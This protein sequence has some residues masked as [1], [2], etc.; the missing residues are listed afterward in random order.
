[1]QKRGKGDR[2][3]QPHPIRKTVVIE[4]LPMCGPVSLQ[5]RPKIDPG[6]MGAGHPL[7]NSRIKPQTVVGGGAVD[8]EI[9]LARGIGPDRDCARRRVR[10]N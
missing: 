6:R 9:G 5:Q 8:G 2:F 4:R 3:P 7:Q 10:H 1:M